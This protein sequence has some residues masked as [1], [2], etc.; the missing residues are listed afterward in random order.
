[1][2]YQFF[3]DK[4]KQANSRSLPGIEAHQEM[5]P[6]NRPLKRQDIDNI[7][8]YRESAVAIVCYPKN[9]EI[10]SLV[11]QRPTYDGIHGGQI[12]FP[13]GKMEQFDASFEETARR[14]TFEEIG[15]R[16]DA[17]E[18]L[19]ELTEMYIPV[20]RFIVH[21]YVYFTQ[22]QPFILDEREVDSI[23]EYPLEILLNPESRKT[24]HIKFANGMTL[25]DVPY[26]AIEEKIVWGAT[27]IILNELKHI[28]MR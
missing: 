10:Y 7:H 8:E 26:F 12:S 21:P 1:M 25:K 11:V 4:I 15:W 27:S 2:N 23:I 19:L 13:G 6:K 24:T 16:L 5:T 9:N 17:S 28:F 14:E 20:S 18:L 22:E 3:I